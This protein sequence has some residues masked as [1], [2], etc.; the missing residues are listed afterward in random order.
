M[1]PFS[2]LVS[3]SRLSF[4][5]TLASRQVVACRAVKTRLLIALYISYVLGDSLCV[6]MKFVVMVFV[7]RHRR[8][9][10]FR[11]MQELWSMCTA[12]RPRFLS[13]TEVHMHHIIWACL[14][15]FL[16]TSSFS[17]VTQGH[18]NLLTELIQPITAEAK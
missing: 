8:I 12:P 5:I 15:V 10:R 14:Q 2:S 4:Y 1:Q 9:V 13:L 7:R 3:D 17:R 18:V 6:Q 16:F 11:H